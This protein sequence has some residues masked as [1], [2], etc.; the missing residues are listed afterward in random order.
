M[1]AI[2]RLTAA[3]QGTTFVYFTKRLPAFL[4]AKPSGNLAAALAAGMRL[5]E[6][7]NDAYDRLTTLQKT[8]T[9]FPAA[10]AAL[11]PADIAAAATVTAAAAGGSACWVPQGAAVAEASDGVA[12]LVDDLVAHVA[13][14]P[15]GHGHRTWKVVFASGTGTMALYAARRFAQ[16]QQQQNSVGTAFEVVAVP[17]VGDARGLLAQMHALD[18]ASGSHGVFPT[19]LGLLATQPPPPLPAATA[20]SSSS[21]SVPFGTP[22]QAH[23]DIWR[24]LKA[25]TSAAAGTDVDFDLVYAPRAFELLRDSFERDPAFWHGAGVLYYHCGGTEGNE[26]QLGRY[27][28]AKLLT[29]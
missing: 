27:R 29:S 13:A 12:G 17:C 1:A 15:S 8:T 4:A 22:C 9:P 2:A 5:V 18:A 26:S 19:V 25:A 28:H 21:A 23:L 14:L 7:P 6:V 3:T 11:L 24:E 10:A 16:L 20:T